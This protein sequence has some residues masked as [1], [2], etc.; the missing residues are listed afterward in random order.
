MKNSIFTISSQQAD[1][2]ANSLKRTA[3]ESRDHSTTQI[4][5]FH[6]DG[7]NNII[8]YVNPHLDTKESKKNESP[9]GQ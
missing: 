4:A 8:I 1:N 7:M 2:F 6:V 3:E 5:K 9:A